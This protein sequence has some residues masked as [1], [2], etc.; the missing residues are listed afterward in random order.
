MPS[1]R[2]SSGPRDLLHW[3]ADSWLLNYL[4]SPFNY[5]LS[6]LE[7]EDLDFP[8][9][10]VDGRPPTPFWIQGS[11]LRLLHWQADFLPSEPPGK[12]QDPTYLEA[13]K[14]T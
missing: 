3:Q 7:R 4:G 9:D 12:P 10:T 8:G 1:S 14:K 13:K 5:T 2:G 11:K 6:D